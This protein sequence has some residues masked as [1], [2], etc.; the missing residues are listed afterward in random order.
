MA[1]RE[2]PQE[3]TASFAETLEKTKLINIEVNNEVKKSFIAYAMA[4][5]VSRAIPDVETD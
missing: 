1:K 2:A 4:V 3:L 5:N